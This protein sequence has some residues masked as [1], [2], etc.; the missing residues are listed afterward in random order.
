MDEIGKQ[1]SP[2]QNKIARFL[3]VFRFPYPNFDAVL[4][5]VNRLNFGNIHLVWDDLGKPIKVPR[6]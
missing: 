3:L 5:D 4:A 1:I 2:E 6:N